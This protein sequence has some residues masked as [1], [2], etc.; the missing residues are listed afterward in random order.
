MPYHYSS[1]LRHAA[2]DAF[3]I[4]FEEGGATIASSVCRPTITSPDSWK[5]VAQGLA[6]KAVAFGAQPKKCT[7]GQLRI[8]RLNHVDRVFSRHS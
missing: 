8:G 3:C 1:A 2:L 5:Q 4:E 6:A 7:V